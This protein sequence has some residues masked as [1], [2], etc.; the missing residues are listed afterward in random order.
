MPDMDNGHHGGHRGRRYPIYRYAVVA[1]PVSCKT[2]YD[3][4]QTIDALNQILSGCNNLKLQNKASCNADFIT[5]VQN[6]ITK[7][8]QTAVPIGQS[9]GTTPYI[10]NPI[11]Y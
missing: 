9:C 3:N 1:R 11:I 7:Q 10:T 8:I 6:E 5:A 2:V 4:T